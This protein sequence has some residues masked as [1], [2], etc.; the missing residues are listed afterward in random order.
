MK[1]SDTIKAQLLE[2]SKNLSKYSVRGE[3]PEQLVAYSQV[4]LNLAG[5]YDIIRNV[6][7]HEEFHNG[8]APDGFILPGEG[9]LSDGGNH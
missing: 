4:V 7:L 8:Q 1:T 5:S 9:P 3:R 2:F 6:E